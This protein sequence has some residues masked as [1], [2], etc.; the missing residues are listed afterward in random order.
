MKH[1]IMRVDEVN[2]NG[3]LYPKAVVEKVIKNWPKNGMP[4][5]VGMSYDIEI[6]ITDIAF[7]A[8]NPEMVDNK[9]MVE[10]QLLETPTGRIAQVLNDNFVYVTSGVGTLKKGV[11]QP[12]YKINSVSIIPK[13]ESSW[14][15]GEW[16]EDET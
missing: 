16:L 11:A 9:L 10:I 15:E 5:K 7:L 8:H 4:G 2:R 6:K 1:E 12:D 3:R 14:E 13:K